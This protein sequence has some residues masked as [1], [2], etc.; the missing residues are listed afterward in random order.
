M[1]KRSI[2][3]IVAVVVVSAAMWLGG[4]S[5]WNVILAMHGRR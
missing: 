1:N 2:I 4:H 3:V 5:L